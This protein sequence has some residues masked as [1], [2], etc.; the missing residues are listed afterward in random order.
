MQRPLSLEQGLLHWLS[1]PNKSVQVDI[2]KQL[3][4]H[5]LQVPEAD[6]AQSLSIAMGL[7]GQ[8]DIEDPWAAPALQTVLLLRDRLDPPSL[9]ALLPTLLRL[10]HNHQV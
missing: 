3:H 2:H 7:A 4:P 5:V 6:A 1:L 8:A 10:Q 9:A